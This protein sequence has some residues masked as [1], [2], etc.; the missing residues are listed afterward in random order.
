MLKN[1]YQHL[2]V[3]HPKVKMELDKS[4]KINIPEP[5]FISG[6]NEPQKFAVS[7]TEGP[8]LV[9]SGAGTGKTKVLTSRLA[10]IIYK[11][12]AKTSE[13][14]AVTFTNKAAME[15]KQRVESILRIPVEGM[16]IGTFHSIGVRFLRK[17]SDL[18]ELKSDF[19]ILDVDDQLRLLKQVI[20]FLDLDP[21]I[22]V[23]KNFL[24]MIDQVKNAGL[25]VDNVSEHEFEKQTN[26]KISKVFT[27]YQKRLINFNS[28][29]LIIAGERGC[30][31]LGKYTLVSPSFPYL[32]KLIDSI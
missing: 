1:G 11:R 3:I 16:Y 25:F 15:M 14:L 5:D 9:L 8:L 2:L 6:L 24:Y 32:L 21:K 30:F 12:L 23:P 27:A 18:I 17:H 13:I 10:N 29:V 7:N 20:G 22:Y 4:K 28:V 26:G 19:T 31:E